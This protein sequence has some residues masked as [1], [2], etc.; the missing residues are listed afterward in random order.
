MRSPLASCASFYHKTCDASAEK[1]WMRGFNGAS[2]PVIT[3]PKM[4]AINF[5]SSIFIE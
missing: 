3:Y 4:H 2:D 5:Y 1:C